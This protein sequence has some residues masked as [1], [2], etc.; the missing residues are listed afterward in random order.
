MQLKSAK[1]GLEMSA[2]VLKQELSDLRQAIM[3][4]DDKTAHSK[5]TQASSIQKGLSEVFNLSTATSKL[6]FNIN[7]CC[8]FRVRGNPE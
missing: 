3:I 2:A 1:A 4:Y 6:V 7:N 8:H 5:I